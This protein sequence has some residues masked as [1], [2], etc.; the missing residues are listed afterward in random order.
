MKTFIQICLFILPLGMCG[1][2]T[3][4]LGAGHSS[5]VTVQSSDYIP[6][7]SPSFTITGK[8]MDSKLFEA[9]RFLHHATMGPR[10]AMAAELVENGN[11]FNQW[12]DDQF[13]EPINYLNPQLEIIWQSIV[14]Y[15]TAQGED[16]NDIFGPYKPHFDYTWWNINVTKDDL[17][18][19]KI[20]Y[21]LAQI[22]VVSDNSDLR[23]YAESLTGYYD[24]LL[25]HSFGNFRDILLD[26]TYSIQ[27]GY[28]LSHFNNAKENPELNTSPDENYAREIMQ[29]FSIGLYELNPD[30][31]RV[32][33]A[34]GDYIASYGQDDIQEFAKIFTGLGVGELENPDNWPYT[35]FFGLD[36]WA[37]KKDAPMVMYQDFHETSE[38]TLLNGTVIPA[39]QTG[40]QDISDAIDNLFNHQNVGPFIG[41]LLIKRLVK[42]NPSPEYVGRVSAAFNDNGNGVRGD[43]KAFIKAI[44]LDEEARSGE[45]MLT[46]D[47]GRAREPMTKVTNMVLGLPLDTNTDTYWG[48]NYGYRDN[49]GQSMFSAPTVF[50]YYPP[51]FQPVGGLSDANLSSPE[52]KLHNT[53]TAIKTI[54]Q[55]FAQNYW[56]S[57]LL[58]DWENDDGELSDGVYI[59]HQMLMQY[60]EQPE[61]LVNELDKILTYGQLTDE[62][63]D[64]IIPVLHDTY[65]TWNDNWRLERIK[66][67]LYFILL[68]PDFNIMK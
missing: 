2:Y 28:Y 66:S 11:D 33:D 35:P 31:T 43:M 4:Y 29:L 55:F 21:A 53:S 9:S 15:R 13:N 7:S 58:S 20:A 24:I 61:I 50:N 57:P 16:E 38:K 65:W 6:T 42:S 8:G 37:S 46:E 52:L 47:A 3:D 44:L 54:N 40:E 49:M 22:F 1:Q 12:I 26:V 25:E 59:D 5:G 36:I 62:T 41:T 30:G 48:V 14:D 51:N 68:S 64:I 27:M 18:R 56:E 39:N 63:R 60:A 67:A 34:N 45:S 17:L 19:H 32:L 23:D 10:P